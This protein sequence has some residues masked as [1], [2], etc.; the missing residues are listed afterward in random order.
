MKKPPLVSVI[1]PTYN[2]DA[3]LAACLGSVRAQTY[4]H[5]ELIVVDNHSSDN[6]LEIAK[7]FTDHA[8]TKGPERSAQRN[9][10]VDKASGEYVCIIDSD[11]ELSPEVITQCVVALAGNPKIHGAIIPEESFGEGFWADCKQLER[12]FYTGIDWMEAARFF[13][14]ETYQKLGGYDASLVSGEDW[15]LSQRVAA[16]APHERISALIFHN[17]GRLKLGRTLGK[18][19]YY[20]KLITRYLAK[21]SHAQHV[22]QQTSPLGRY[23]LF[24]SQ[25]AKLFRRPHVG[26]GML[27]MKTMEFGAGAIG[28]FSA[29]RQTKEALA[30]E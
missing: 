4:D 27:F 12:S 14:R 23:A 2:S 28:M 7:S 17:E 5:I 25:P 1:V 9:F 21:T 10:G 3:T 29:K 20:A 30:D 16:V 13:D 15:D 26:I 19:Y 6:T 24:L 8:Y 18:K 11:M 22:S